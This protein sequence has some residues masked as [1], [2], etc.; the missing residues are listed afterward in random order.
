QARTPDSCMPTTMAAPSRDTSS[1]SSPKERRPTTGF[2]GRLATSSTGA[3]F[4]FTPSAAN[5]VP[6]IRP[7]ARASSDDRVAPKAMFPGS[8]VAPPS[9][10]MS[11]PPSWSRATNGLGCPPSRAASCSE[12]VSAWNCS[13]PAKLKAKRQ[14]PGTRPSRRAARTQS[15]ASRPRKLTRQCATP[16]ALRSGEGDALDEV[17][18][19]EQEDDQDG[20]HEQ[21]A[22]RHD[23]L[24]RYGRLLQVVLL[25]DVDGHREQLCLL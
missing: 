24:P 19:C 17:P 4:M 12:R 15:G 1:T 14:T 22:G 11:W 7:A 21:D 16:S 5:S 23:V 2:R 13:T 9:M 18:L 20:D 8:S 10:A 3:R 6:S 25:S